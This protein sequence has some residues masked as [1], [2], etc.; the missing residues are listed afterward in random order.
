MHH[1][2]DSGSDEFLS[3]DGDGYESDEEI[4]EYPKDYMYVDKSS[5]YKS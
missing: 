4:G 2:S 1:H 5:L 3:F